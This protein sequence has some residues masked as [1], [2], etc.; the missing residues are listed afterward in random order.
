MAGD[1]NIRDKNWDPLFPF[2]SIHSDLLTDITDSLEVF[3]SNST[4]ILAEQSC[5]ISSL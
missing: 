3:L 2:H 4:K 5:Y 1:F